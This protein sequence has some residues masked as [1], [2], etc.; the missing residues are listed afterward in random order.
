MNNFILS[1]LSRETFIS[2]DDLYPK[3]PD[4]LGDRGSSIQK[5]DLTVN[6][7]NEKHPKC[8]RIAIFSQNNV[9]PYVQL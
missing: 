7:L 4:Y 2:G 1:V 8:H 9:V 5:T 6:Q 3:D